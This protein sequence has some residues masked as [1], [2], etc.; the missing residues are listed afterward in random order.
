LLK[1]RIFEVLLTLAFLFSLAC[2]SKPTTVNA[3]IGN[4]S[5]ADPGLLFATKE[6]DVYQAEAYLTANGSTDRYFIARNG[7]TRRFDTYAGEYAAMTE[8]IKD[9]N[10]Y[11][12]DHSRKAY[13]IEPPSEKG[14]MAIDPASFAIFQNTV[15]HEFEAVVRDGDTV[16]YHAKKLAGDPNEDVLVTVDQKTGLVIREEVKAADSAQAFT[17]ELKNVKFEAPDDLFHIPAGYTQVSKDGLKAP[18]KGP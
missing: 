6:P 5:P 10:R 8:L 3:P 2:A 17:F 11:V 13:Y 12:V 4:T 18:K 16:T 1:I 15:H 7:A 14:P 9:N